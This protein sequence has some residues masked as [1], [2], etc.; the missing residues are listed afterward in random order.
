MKAVVFLSNF[1]HQIPVTVSSIELISGFLVEF[2][3]C[4]SVPQ[5]D[6]FLSHFFLLSLFMNT[7][8]LFR[9]VGRRH[10]GSTGKTF[11]YINYWLLSN[12]EYG[13]IWTLGLVSYDRFC[14]MGF[15][16]QIFK[17]S[18]WDWCFWNQR[19]QCSCLSAVNERKKKYF[20]GGIG[21]RAWSKHYLGKKISL[22][23]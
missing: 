14:G 5:F 12:T 9:R 17:K 18:I 21:V 23:M 19:F 16:M 20:C 6:T 15:V 10:L 7:L 1:S 2:F 11:P 3:S 8:T 13:T 22:K 4:P